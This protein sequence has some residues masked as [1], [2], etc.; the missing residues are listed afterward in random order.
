MRSQALCCAPAALILACAPEPDPTGCAQYRRRIEEYGY[1][2]MQAV[3]DMPDRE[4][5]LLRCSETGPWRDDCQARW[6]E[7]WNHADS[8]VSTEDLLAACP[9]DDCKFTVL[10]ARPE[11]DVLAQVEKCTSDAGALGEDCARHALHRWVITQPSAEEIQRVLVQRRSHHELVA[12]YAG[13]SIGCTGQGQC[14]DWDAQFCREG[15]QFAQ[16][17]PTVCKTSRAWPTTAVPPAPQ[18]QAPR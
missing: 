2:L 7:R 5:A 4:A 16:T 10:D 15:A 17:D 12:H 11:T 8:P 18:P 1:C 3:P 6:V 14:V 9:T 13:Q